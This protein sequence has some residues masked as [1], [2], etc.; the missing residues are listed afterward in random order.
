MGEYSVLNTI[1]ALFHYQCKVKVNFEILQKQFS[2]IS[3]KFKQVVPLL[4]IQQL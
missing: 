2:R 1:N 4:L 3:L